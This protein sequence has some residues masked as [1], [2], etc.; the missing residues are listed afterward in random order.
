M[1]KSVEWN[2]EYGTGG[3]LNCLCDAC[4]KCVPI[5]FKKTPDRTVYKGS[6][7]K[8]KAK[9]WVARKLGDTWYDFCSDECFDEFRDS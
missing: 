5:K 9:G 3:I 6:N 4:G 2:E 1:S 7:E 8:L